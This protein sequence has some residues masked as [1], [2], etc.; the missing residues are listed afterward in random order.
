MVPQNHISLR[1]DKLLRSLSS[2]PPKMLTA[3]SKEN[4]SEFVLYELSHPN[5]FNFSKAA[6]FVDNPDFNCFK[7]ISGFN[8]QE[9]VV[10]GHTCWDCPETLDQSMVASAFNQKVRSISTP[11]LGHS[12]DKNKAQLASLADSLELSKPSYYTWHL[13]HDNHGILIF[14]HADK[15]SNPDYEQHVLQGVSLLG[16]CP[17]Y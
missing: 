5:C 16:F 12:I 14:E 1:H 11:S 6:Y 17:I 7:G 10:N 13:K 4:L 9:H 8:C 2:L 15:E 3:H